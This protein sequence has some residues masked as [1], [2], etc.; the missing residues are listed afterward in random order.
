[1]EVEQIAVERDRAV[2]VGDSEVHMF[3]EH[4]ISLV[5]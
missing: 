5:R 3:E 4:N 2:E 1:V